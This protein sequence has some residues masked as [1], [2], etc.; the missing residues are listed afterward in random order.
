MRRLLHLAVLPVTVLILAGIV[1]AVG[2]EKTKAAVENAGAGAF[3]A[4]GV[5]S[6]L[7]IIFQAVAWALLNRPI[8][9]HV[10]FRTLVGGTIVGQAGN[11]MTPSTYLGGEA[12]R[13]AYVGRL[14]KLPYHEVAGAV[15]LSKYL[16]FVSFILLLSFSTLVA[17]VQYREE[18]FG[19]HLWG[20]VGMLAVAALSLGFGVVLWVSLVR[21]RRP[22]TRLVGWLARLRPLTRKLVRLRGQTAKME[23]QVSRVFCEEGAISLASFGMLLASHALIFTKPMVFFLLAGGHLRLN[24]GQLCLIFAAGQL[25]LAVQIFPSGAGMFDGGL[26]GTFAILGLDEGMCMAY[27]LCLRLWDAVVIGAGVFLGARIGTRILSTEAVSAVPNA[28]EPNSPPE[29]PSP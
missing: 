8:K 5:V 15:V 19:R 20:G 10:P 25:I 23:D 17:A 29:L 14:A 9:H 18:L 12:F 4:V 13:V 11:I 2:F 16:E 28:Q 6:A 27:L 1:W 21:R 24:L 7:F 3:V 26:L 22:L